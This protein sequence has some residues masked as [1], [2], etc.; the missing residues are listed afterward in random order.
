[1]GISKYEELRNLRV[2]W[3]QEELAKRLTEAGFGGGG[4]VD[5]ILQQSVAALRLSIATIDARAVGSGAEKGTATVPLS[6]VG[7]SRRSHGGQR[8]SLRSITIALQGNSERRPVA[9]V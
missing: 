5:T 9:Q 4:A 3:N 1:M 8:R 2:L 6:S 7:E